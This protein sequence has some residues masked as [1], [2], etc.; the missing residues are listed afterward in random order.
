MTSLP[1]RDHHHELNCKSP[2]LTYVMAIYDYHP[3]D[4]CQLSF[5]EG[6]LIKVLE[7]NATG[8]FYCWIDWKE[9]WVPSTFVSDAI[10]VGNTS[11]EEE[12]IFQIRDQSI[13]NSDIWRKSLGGVTI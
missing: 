4:S 13:K 10:H 5:K 12:I 3:S 9:G 6:R 7:I 2:V 8:W 1:R 11:S